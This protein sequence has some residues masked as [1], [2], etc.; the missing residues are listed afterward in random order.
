MESAV[1]A[2]RNDGPGQSLQRIGGLILRYGL[3]LMLVWIGALKFA[4]YEA[5]GVQM[6]AS[7]SP[8]LSWGTA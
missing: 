3:V 4:K 7:H 6:L 2:T 5:E 1:N 8:L